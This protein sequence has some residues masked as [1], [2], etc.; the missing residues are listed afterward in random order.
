MDHTTEALTDYATKLRYTDLSPEAVH[1]LKRSFIDTLGCA[2]GGSTG[3]PSMIAKQVA[4]FSSS[5]EL[6]SRILGSADHS[7]PDMAAFANTVQVQFLNFDE[8]WRELNFAG[9]FPGRTIPAI[10]ALADPLKSSGQAVLTATAVAYEVAYRFADPVDLHTL[11]WNQ[12]WHVGPASAAGLVNLLGLTRE[13]GANALSMTAINGLRT[14]QTRAGQMTMWKAVDCADANRDVV[15]YA[16]LARQGMTAPAEPF[17]GQWGL[18][19][20]SGIEAPTPAQDYVKGRQ[21]EQEHLLELEPF[22]IKKRAFKVTRMSQKIYPTHAHGL[23]PIT[24]ALELRTK[25]RL[26]DIEEINIEG[27]YKALYNTGAG[28]DKAVRFDPQTPEDANHSIPWA[29]AV[30]LRD[31]TFGPRSYESESL[32]DPS[33]RPLMRKVHLIENPEFS[34]EYP[35]VHNM[36]MEIVTRSGERHTAASRYPKGYFENPLTDAEL[37]Q[38]FV[39]L[40]EELIGASRCREALDLLWRLDELKTLAPVFDALTVRAVPEKVFA[41]AH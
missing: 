6:P 23:A 10:L 38:K 21:A 15:L 5:R 3:E 9:A 35:Q 37:E 30:A 1:S 2:I 12:S 32:R 19:R 14:R 20:M 34:R 33:L 36:T 25:V 29:V 39:G 40:T 22:D 4:A 31:G 18:W 11:H 17:D 13:Q 7:S 16:L 8:L 24:M 41:R 27:Y 28:P 26:D